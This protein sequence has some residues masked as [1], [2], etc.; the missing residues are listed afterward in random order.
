MRKNYGDS[1]L[2]EEGKDEL[3]TG[4]AFLFVLGI[5]LI[6]GFEK[7]FEFN[8]QSS[9]FYL[10]SKNGKIFDL[11]NFKAYQIFILVISLL[12]K[13]FAFIYSLFLNTHTILSIDFLSMI[14]SLPVSLIL[15]FWPKALILG[16][17]FLY[18]GYSNLFPVFIVLIE[19]R[20]TLNNLNIVMFFLINHVFT[21]TH[22]WIYHLVS[23]QGEIDYFFVSLSFAILSIIVLSVMIFY[24]ERKRLTDDDLK[25]Y[26]SEN[27]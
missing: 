17:F 18:L 16:F 22:E 10:F 1:K 2:Y 4:Y 20:F 21:I 9:L 3:S 26:L 13:I 24:F 6:S 19:E 12:T 23:N 8:S 25:T 14:L 7:L 15:Q 5:S 27:Y 11:F